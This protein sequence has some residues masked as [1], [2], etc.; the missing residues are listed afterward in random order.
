MKNKINFYKKGNKFNF[1][2]DELRRPKKTPKGTSISSQR[3]A[4]EKN[5]IIIQ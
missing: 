1:N 4:S 3:A 2:F 5:Y